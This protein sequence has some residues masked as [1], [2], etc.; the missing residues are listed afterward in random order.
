MNKTI[1]IAT[2]SGG[3]D[4]TAMC[5]LLLKNGYPV[6]YI[7]FKDTLHEFDEMYKYVKKVNEYF[8]L[9]Y[10]KQITF[11]KPTKTLEDM[12]YGKISD[13]K[14]STRAGQIRGLPMP[15]GYPCWWRR[16]AKNHPFDKWLKDKGIKEHKIYIGFTSDEPNRKMQG[17]N[18]LYP[19][20]D[21]F[22]MSEKDCQEYL[23]N[24][25]MENPLYKHFTRTGCSFC[26]AQSDRSFYQVWKHYPKEWEYMKNM[27]KELLKLEERGEIIQN[28]HWFNGKRTCEEMEKHFIQVDK[29]GS[30]FD[31]SDE[32]LKDCFCKI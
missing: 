21:D 2:I 24:Q 26:P 12:V 1:Y 29:Q 15:I 4:S 13:R 17:D 6:D 20:I 7:V 16:E 18:F 31:F 25:E 14:G 9:R 8:K 28:K 27:E 3:K 5:D 32:P 22:K 30:L 11:L 10:K 19:L 23:I